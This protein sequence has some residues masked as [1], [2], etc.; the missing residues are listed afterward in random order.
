MVSRNRAALIVAA[1]VV[2]AAACGGHKPPETKAAPTAPGFVAF[3]DSEARRYALLLQMVD[4]HRV[5]EVLLK[6][7]LK[8]GLASP[9]RAEAARA[10]GQVR[11]RTVASTLRL[12]LQAKD[13]AVAASAAFALG[14]MVDTPSVNLLAT[15]ITAPPIYAPLPQN[16]GQAPGYQ[17]GRTNGRPNTVTVAV[18]ASPVAREAAWALSELGEAARKPIERALSGGFSTS[19]VVYAAAK[20]NPVPAFLLTTYVSPGNAALLRAA[21][22]SLTRSRS[23][24]AARSLMNPPAFRSPDPETRAYV[25]RGLAHSAAGDSL[26]KYAL[27]V[28]DTMAHDSVAAVRISALLSL[29][30]YG[31]PARAPVV[32]ALRDFDPNVR[33]AAARALDSTLVGAPR[34]DWD[35][36]FAADTSLAFR[37]TLVASATL[38]G[39]ILPVIDK[40]N[41]DRWQRSGDWRY[42]A[43]AARA[44]SGTS[45][46]RIVD[47]A[48]PLTRD[49]DPRVRAAAYQVFA[50][51]AGLSVGGTPHPWRRE[52]MLT[53]VHDNDAAVRAVGLDGLT[54]IAT[55]ADVPAVAAAY[56]AAVADSAPKVRL[57]AARCL[58]A[59]WRRDSAA[60]APDA[61]AA[62]TALPVPDD[63]GILDAVRGVSLFATWRPENGRS[64]LHPVDWYLRIVHEIVEPT[65]RGQAPQVNIQTVRGNITIELYGADAP[66][67][68]DNFLT[69]TKRDFYKNTAFHRVV[70]GF[71]A[72]DGD[73]RGD[74]LGGPGYDIRDELNRRRYVRGAVGMAL[75][76]PNTGGS[77]YF[78][79]LASAPHLDGHYTTFGRV[80]A[81]DAALDQI[82]QW[83]GI[84]NIV[85]LVRVVTP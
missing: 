83:D 50:D 13:T 9:L 57:A 14:L 27:V 2:T 82:V 40:D 81:G 73:P 77:Q 59:I 58:V 75:D 19:I 46:E 29:R 84:D 49:P 39:V 20:L 32:V 69:L 18:V 11:A 78:I 42:R 79:A 53:A 26:G 71:V 56:Q 64:D 5:D 16:R 72:Q 35:H 10:A 67:T 4:A 43:A 17:T 28:L 21:T 31:A 45:M 74:G 76:G 36:A 3:A 55:A 51:A 41:P 62:V 33:I 48:L 44:A 6:E 65:L 8:P 80:I 63:A 68:V 47:L 15:A 7:S 38:A 66:V 30:G 24:A 1:A 52:Y 12:L 37:S 85:P 60:V 70:P 54:G 61:K 34:G 23:P 22:Y 25:A